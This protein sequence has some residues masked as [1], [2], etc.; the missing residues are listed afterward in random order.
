MN[1]YIKLYSEFKIN[2]TTEFNLQRMNPDSAQMAV[3]V[4]NPQLSINAFDKHQDVIRAAV[5][6]INS[7]LYSLSNT[8]QYKNLK[9]K[10]SLESQDIT[11]MKVI[12]ISKSN[13]VDYDVYVSFVIDENE[14][15]GVIEDVL[16]K[17]P[18]FKSEVFK[19]TSL[20]LTKE[21]MIKTKGLVV[22]IIKKWLTPENGFYKLLNDSVVCYDSLTGNQKQITKDSQVEVVRA[23]DNKIVIKFENKYYHLVGETY[24]Y[25]NYWFIKTK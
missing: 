18:N 23:Y 16:S 2:E 22:R 25:F 1:K 7:L 6:K 20:I 5:S 14:Y 10:I 9:S 4:D 24:V 8:S 12:R 19:N 21:W 15:W 17:D 11:S 13:D 3:H